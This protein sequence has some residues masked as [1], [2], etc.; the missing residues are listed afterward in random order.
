MNVLS[1][2][3]LKGLVLLLGTFILLYGCSILNLPS[4]KKSA[5]QINQHLKNDNKAE[6]VN[7]L[8]PTG[9]AYPLI[10]SNDPIWIKVS[11][12][13]QRVYIM[14]EN[15]IIYTMICSTGLDK[16]SDTFTPEGTFYIQKE[17]GL[18]FYN[19]QEKEGAKYWV[20][21]KNHGEFLF[22]SVAT[23][24]NGNVIQSEAMK[25]GHKASHGCVRLAVPDAKW[26]YDNIRYNT[27][28][29]IS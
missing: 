2:L 11:K 24:K 17:R 9:G 12:E 8:M 27:K 6:P 21:W 13:K 23:D 5:A 15:K 29:V 22:H 3:F 18:S 20:S 1:R 4:D 16:N 28:V 25:L 19:A 26:I 10:G 7:W 14:K